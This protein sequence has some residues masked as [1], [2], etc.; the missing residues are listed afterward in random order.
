MTE[1]YPLPPTVYEALPS[2]EIDTL[3]SFEGEHPDDAIDVEDA[4]LVIAALQSVGETSRDIDPADDATEAEAETEP[5][6]PEE[7]QIAEEQVARLEL[8]KLVVR[9]VSGDSHA[10]SELLTTI[11][12]RIVGYCY[13]RLGVQETPKGSADDIVQEICLGVIDALPKFQY[14]GLSFYSFV[15]QIAGHKVADSFRA[16]GRNRSEPVAEVPDRQTTSDSHPDDCLLR[17]ELSEE[18]GKAMNILP[19]RQRNILTLRVVDGFSAEETAR[20][21]GSTPGAVRVAQHRALNTL[22]ANTPLQAYTDAPQTQ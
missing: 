11:Y 21:V 9:A 18:L 19:D 13:N 1:P 14:R 7:R 17:L 12:P 3:S 6:T 16:V 22:R 8:D 10:V 4:V 2:E 15:Y 5:Y 20:T